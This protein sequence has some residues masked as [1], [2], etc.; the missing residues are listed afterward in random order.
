[1]KSQQERNDRIREMT[2]TGLSRQELAREFGPTPTSISNVLRGFKNEAISLD[3][4]LHLRELLKNAD[5]LDRKWPVEDLIDAIGVGGVTRTGLKRHF[6]WAGL[7]E[8]TLRHMMDLTISDKADPRPG[9]LITPL[10]GLRWLSIVSFWSMVNALT[11]VDM[12]TRCN[13]HWA[14]KLAL[15]RQSTRILADRPYSWSKPIDRPIPSQ[16]SS[17]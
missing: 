8:T 4:R 1:M 15:L 5:D 17:E 3:R 11:E 16:H 9:Y 7:A 6:E 14:S 13:K 12:G 10:L 2:I